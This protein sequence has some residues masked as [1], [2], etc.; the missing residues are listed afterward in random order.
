MAVISIKNKIKS[1]SLLVGNAAYMPP[2]FES[3]VTTTVGAG[4]AASITFNSIPQT[5][6]HLQIRLFSRDSRVGDNSPIKIQFNSDTTT[7]YARHGMYG[8]GSTVN[9][10]SA[11]SATEIWFM[12]AGNSGTSNVFGSAIVDVLDYASSTKNKTTKTL[13]GMDYN[14]AGFSFAW[15]GLWNNTSPITSIT[16]TPFAPNFLEHSSFALYGIKG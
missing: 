9:A 15:S 11:S 8:T 7:S 16:L 3:I 2:S 13:G 6:Q 10:E 5:Y 12:G 1:G 4:G 14:G